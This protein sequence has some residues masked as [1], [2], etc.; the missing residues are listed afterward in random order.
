MIN[1]NLSNKVRFYGKIARID[2]SKKFIKKKYGI[3]L[4]KGVGLS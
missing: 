1:K 2:Y 3:N 4:K